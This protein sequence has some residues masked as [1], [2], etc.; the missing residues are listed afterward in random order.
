MPRTEYRWLNVN[1]NNLTDRY[2]CVEELCFMVLDFIDGRTVTVSFDPDIQLLVEKGQANLIK[3]GR[4]TPMADYDLYDDTHIPAV[5]E[6]DGK[7][8]RVWLRTWDKDRAA[9]RV[10]LFFEIEIDDLPS[11]PT[12]AASST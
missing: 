11:T 2:E 7:Q 3:D 10:G 4:G 8:Y 9:P 6:R 12:G 1:L 5:I